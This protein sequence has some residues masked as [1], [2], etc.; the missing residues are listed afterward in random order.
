M[1]NLTWGRFIYNPGSSYFVTFRKIPLISGLLFFSVMADTLVSSQFQKKS[2]G[3]SMKELE[4]HLSVYIFKIAMSN[5]HSI[6]YNSQINV[7]FVHFRGG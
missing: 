2:N 4:S 7:Y 5:K 3:I 1:D 6:Q